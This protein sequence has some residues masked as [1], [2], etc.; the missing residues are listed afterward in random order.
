MIQK[1]PLYS[2]HLSEHAKDLPMGK[3]P[4]TLRLPIASASCDTG[5]HCANTLDAS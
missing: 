4:L 3:Q 5:I 1:L 2:S